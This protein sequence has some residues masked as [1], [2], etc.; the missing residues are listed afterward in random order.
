MRT[1][2]V[3]EGSPAGI[4]SLRSS[5]RIA[6]RTDRNRID[7]QSVKVWTTNP[8]MYSSVLH[9]VDDAFYIRV[10]NICS[11][12]HVC[13]IAFSGWRK[14]RREREIEITTM[15][16]SIAAPVPS[17]RADTKQTDR[18]ARVSFSAESY[19]RSRHLSVSSSTLS[20]TK[21]SECFIFHYCTRVTT[22]ASLSYSPDDGV[23]AKISAY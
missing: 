18:P 9:S 5:W 14:Q 3:C 10:F 7:V 6:L 13:S 1:A 12:A 19:A 8:A 17:N 23:L 16:A 15:P 4:V 11:R 21:H 20:P 2:G 22:R